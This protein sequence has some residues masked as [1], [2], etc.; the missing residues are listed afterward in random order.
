[1]DLKLAT[2]SSGFAVCAT[3]IFGGWD[4]LLS[5]LIV[6]IVL[7]YIT[8]IVA[9]GIDG[10][11]NSTTGLKGIAKKV[12]IL[13]IVAL[14]VQIDCVSAGDGVIRALVMYF[15]IANEGLSIVENAGQVGLPIPDGLVKALEMLKDKD[16]KV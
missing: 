4:K 3:F 12:F 1:M 8:G 10:K 7:D 15:F 5:A 9:A 16:K 13:M 2:L 6:L 14:A 11:L